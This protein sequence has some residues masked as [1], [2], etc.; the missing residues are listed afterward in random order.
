MHFCESSNLV[1]FIKTKTCFTFI[2]DYNSVE[3]NRRHRSQLTAT[4]GCSLLLQRKCTFA[5]LCFSLVSALCSTFSLFTHRRCVK[6]FGSYWAPHFVFNSSL[7]W[8][9]F[10]SCHA[11]QRCSGKAFLSLRY[12]FTSPKLQALRMSSQLMWA[13]L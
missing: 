11:E 13:D 6:P 1:H 10:L 2:K 7:F 4:A 9:D 12:S 8:R 5:M 3:D